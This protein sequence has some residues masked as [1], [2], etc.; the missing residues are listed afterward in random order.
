MKEE[1][2][3]F[4]NSD[5]K[6][7]EDLSGWLLTYEF[8]VRSCGRSGEIEMAKIQGLVPKVLKALVNYLE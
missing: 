7:L 3:K 6:L 4:A 2:T 1:M 8:E 5:A